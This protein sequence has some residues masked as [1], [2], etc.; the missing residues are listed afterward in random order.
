MSM[1][2]NTK[3]DSLANLALEILTDEEILRL[4]S[5]LLHSRNIPV[6][7]WSPEDVEEIILERINNGDLPEME[8]PE[9]LA[10]AREIWPG[11]LS[12]LSDCTDNDW[13]IVR[14]GVDRHF[15]INGHED[16]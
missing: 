1:D 10:A 3:I 9:L 7:I 4:G 5:R 2:D 11:E 15:K 13:D 12:G 6:I 14:S 16:D 8:E